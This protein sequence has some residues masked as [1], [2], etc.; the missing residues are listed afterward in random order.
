[1]TSFKISFLLVLLFALFVQTGQS[2]I[3]FSLGP[4]LGLTLPTGDYSGTT[5]D[6]YNGAKYGLSSGINIGAVVKAKLPNIIRIRVAGNYSSLKNSGNSE[7]DKPES[8]VEVKQTVFMLSVGPEFTFGVPKSMITPYAGIDLL[9]TSFSGET[10]FRG[11]SRVP[12][13]TYSMSS[14]TRLG[15]GIGGGVEISFA[16]VHAIDIGL[17]YNLMNLIGKKFE[18]L[19][20]DARV[21]SYV[22]LNDDQDANYAVDPNEHPISNSRSISDFQINVAFLFGF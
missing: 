5:I 20:S 21:D 16:K 14:A 15:I 12:S 19:P 4:S 13:G 6:Y 7:P 10:T 17:R 18:E 11:V 8:F 22:N 9:M 2:Q 1:M 3:K